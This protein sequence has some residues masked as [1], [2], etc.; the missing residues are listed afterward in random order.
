MHTAVER[1]ASG[2]SK[3]HVPFVPPSTSWVDARIPA[4]RGP[5]RCLAHFQA[6]ATVCP[7]LG[8]RKQAAA[9]ARAAGESS[10]AH[11]EL[12][13]WEITLCL[14]SPYEGVTLARMSCIVFPRPAAASRRKKTNKKENGRKC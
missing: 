2:T 3:L 9:R 5:K 12:A 7:L 4:A 1:A 10:Q 6:A 8:R 13:S 11:D 14:L